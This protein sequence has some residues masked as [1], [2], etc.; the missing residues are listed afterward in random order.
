MPSCS[1][2]T[3][4]F[5]RPLPAGPAL[6]IAIADLI[7]LNRS[8]PSEIEREFLC[9]LRNNKQYGLISA[10]LEKN[11]SHGTSTSWW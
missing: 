2:D 6:P 3:Q 11:E 5:I 9:L 10:A 4:V 1:A 8:L 7:L